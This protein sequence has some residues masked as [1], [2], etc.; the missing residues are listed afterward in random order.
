MTL[1][2]TTG[3]VTVTTLMPLIM[4]SLIMVVVTLIVMMAT[5]VSHPAERNKSCQWSHIA[6][7][8]VRS[9][10]WRTA[11]SQQQQARYYGRAKKF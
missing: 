6:M 5:A 10:R 3:T 2:T 11:E 4:T 8:I 9:T 7:A 1:A